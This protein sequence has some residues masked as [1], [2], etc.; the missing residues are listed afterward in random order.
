[1]PPSIRAPGSTGDARSPEGPP[2]T[3]GAAGGSH[4]AGQGSPL[5]PRPDRATATPHGV[6]RGPASTRSGIA[7][8]LA[9]DL[10]GSPELR[11]RRATAGLLAGTSRLAGSAATLLWGRRASG[12]SPT[13]ARGCLQAF[14]QQ[15][16][17]LPVRRSS[18]AARHPSNHENGPRRRRFTDRVLAHR[19]GE[20]LWRVDGR[21]RAQALRRAEGL[22]SGS[23]RCGGQ[24][25]PTRADLPL[26]RS[27]TRGWRLS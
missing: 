4:T 2:S 9:T 20:E 8:M 11:C 1:M 24:T 7:L 18:E 19:R 25:R 22:R 3:V 6:S 17:P 12:S 26:T 23:H 10:Q 14:A 13:R 16:P 21:G 27:R 15:A 5:R